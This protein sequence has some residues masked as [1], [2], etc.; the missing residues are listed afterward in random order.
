M[1]AKNKPDTKVQFIDASGAEFFKKEINNNVMLDKH[2]QK[3]MDIFD[4]K[5]DLDYLAVSVL[6]QQIAENDYNLSVSSYIEAKDTREVIDIIELNAE[7][8]AIAGRI[9]QIRKG[10]RSI[11]AEIDA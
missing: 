11:I 6:Q 3:V 4:R 5:E 1:L 9:D 2:I 8:E 10:I 7:I